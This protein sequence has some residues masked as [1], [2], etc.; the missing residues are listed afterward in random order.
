M[1]LGVTTIWIRPS[2]APNWAG[3]RKSESIGL[4]EGHG[5]ANTE[6]QMY[7]AGGSTSS[8]ITIDPDRRRLHIRGIRICAIEAVSEPFVPDLS[9]PCAEVSDADGVAE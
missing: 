7:R 4:A 1:R 3:D 2:W 5:W 9:T 8:H 6:K